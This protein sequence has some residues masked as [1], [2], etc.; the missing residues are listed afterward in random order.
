[1]ASENPAPF[2][3]EHA[4]A[5]MAGVR[6]SPCPCDTRERDYSDPDFLIG[7]A[8]ACPRCG[9]KWFWDGPVTFLPLRG[10]R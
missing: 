4:D 5:Y 2:V 7:Q 10:P 3:K 6:H 1:M 8:V 9:A